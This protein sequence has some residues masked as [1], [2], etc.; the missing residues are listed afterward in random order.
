MINVNV[1]NAAWAEESATGWQ[2][3]QRKNIVWF[4]EEPIRNTAKSNQAG[5]PIFD[6]VIY[7][8]IRCP[9]DRLL[10]IDRKATNIDRERYAAELEA[11]RR[12]Q[13][14]S[15]GSGT[16]LEMWPQLDRRQVAEFKAMNIFTVEHLATLNEGHA[17]NIMGFQQVKK[18]AETFLRAAQGAVEFERM[19]SEVKKRD[20][21]IAEMRARLAVLEAKPK[22]GRPRKAVQ[23]AA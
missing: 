1:G 6:N 14:T 18:K 3:A 21:V 7:C 16:P 9:G 17:A 10:E 8:H 20:E 12:K 19:E 13:D 5:R 22:K 11:F 15:V 23:A 4:S 2:R